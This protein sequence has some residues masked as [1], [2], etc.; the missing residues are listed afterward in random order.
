MQSGCLG[1]CIGH[2]STVEEALKQ[3]EAKRLPQTAQEVLFSRHL[4]R[5]KQGLDDKT[6]WHAAGAHQCEQLAQANMSSFDWRH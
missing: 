3:Y 4:G 5:M 6:D 1:E 2:C